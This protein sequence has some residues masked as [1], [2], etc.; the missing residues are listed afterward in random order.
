MFH[1]AQLMTGRL[2]G[3]AGE[4]VR[5]LEARWILR[6]RLEPA[7]AGWFGRFPGEAEI[8]EDAYLLD[9][10]LRGISVKVRA[11]TALDVKVYQGSPGILEVA[12]S[13]VGRIQ[14]WQKWSFPCGRLGRGDVGSAG[15]LRVRKRR[16]ISR[17]SL[18]GGETGCAVELTEVRARAEDW[19][20]LG[21][22]ATGPDDLLPGELQAAAA[23]VFARLPLGFAEFCLSDSRSYADWIREAS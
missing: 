9:P 15:W 22:E 7:A 14:Y 19:W 13:A 16:R 5:S 3:R 11:G 8:R 10:R 20:S 1:D 12:G 23:E 17:F 18:A 4:S 6:G 2:G 21:F